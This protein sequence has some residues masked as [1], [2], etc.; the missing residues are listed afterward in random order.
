MNAGGMGGSGGMN[1]GG[2]GGVGGMNV[3]GMG[4]AGG[5]I[6][7]VPG[8]GKACYSGAPGTE[9]IGPCKGGATLCQADGMSYGPCLGE[10]VPLIEECGTTAVDDDCNGLVNDHCGLHIA[11]GTGTNDQAIL[12]IATDSDGN[13]IVT[14]HIAGALDFG[15][16]IMTGFGGL[17]I[18]VSKF[19]KAGNHL[20]SKVY[21]SPTDDEGFGVA[22]DAL[23][24]IYVAGYYTGTM[25][26]DA[27]N[28]PSSDL[29][30]AVIIKLDPIG[31]LTELR[32]LGGL[33]NQ[34]ANGIAVDDVGAVIATGT[35]D[36][37]FNTALGV[38]TSAALLD[39][40]VI[41][42][43]STLT[44]Q[45]QKTFGGSGDDEGV[46]VKTDS[47]NRIYLTGYF[48]ETV[49]FGGGVIGDGGSY[50]VFLAKLD[51]SGNHLLS[52]GFPVS[53]DQFGDVIDV[54]TAGN[55]YIAGDFNVS[56]NMG[57]GL[58]NSAGND[59]AYLTK[60]DSN[61]NHLYTKIY[62]DP[63][64]QLMRAMAID[65]AGDVV[66]ALAHDGVV[67][68]G[69]GPIT[70]VGAA[71][72]NDIVVVKLKGATGDHLWSRR[73]GNASD[74]DVRCLAIDGMNNI[75][76]A[77]EFYGSINVG[78]GTISSSSGRDA[79]LFTLPP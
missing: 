77:G 6:T 9:N 55:I 22:V 59:D 15:A 38:A 62:G 63:V 23:G 30:D 74:Q 16:G 60:F 5:G 50:D 13:V 54:D 47:A 76:V 41:K 43:S 49:D 26:V 64:D 67:D 14:G 39:G 24:N 12:G 3:G 44:E 56:I 7:C 72:S 29:Q 66:F 21:G 32:P 33:G 28:L 45:W 27:M 46:S 17:D 51:S 71:G 68:Y 42:L 36:N 20:W 73:F 79:F 8:T 40:F 65:K 19:D 69:G 75:H 37:Q 61:G 25:V 31:Q 53:G 4:G 18:F 11:R 35:F 2:M 57:G 70:N 78:A 1:A 52:K 48:D 10:V 58:V 34:R